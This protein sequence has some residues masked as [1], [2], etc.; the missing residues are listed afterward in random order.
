MTY[1]YDE[2][3]HDEQRTPRRDRRSRRRKKRGFG[4]FIA[5]VLSLAVISVVVWQGY[6]WFDENVRGLFSGPADYEGPGTDPVDITIPEGAFVRDIGNLLRDS[7]V[8]ESSDAFVNA[9][10]ANPDSTSIQA[11][12]YSLRLE[13]R[14][15]DALNALLAGRVSA[16]ASILIPE[17][18][19]LIQ[20]ITRIVDNED[21]EF[22]AEQIQ[23]VLDSPENLTLPE[24][25]EG[26]VEGFLFPATYEVTANM[27]A[28]DLLQAMADR[29]ETAA[30]EAGLVDGAAARGITPRQAVTIAS[31]V[32]REV[33]NIE[34]MPNVAQVIYNRLN[35]SC[36]SNGVPEGYLQMDSTIHFA[37]GESE[38]VFTSDEQRQI[39]SPYNTY[40]NPGIPPGPIA[41]P[42]DDA[43]SAALNPTDGNLCYF[44]AVN[45]ETGETKFAETE[46]EHI[47]NRR[48]LDAYCADSD[49]C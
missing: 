20:I 7:G 23:A 49:A 34:D 2:L 37:L 24:Y 32:Q 15:V 46:D 3:I 29:F 10:N 17:G 31:I 16:V 11:G 19:R 28:Q 45:L 1:G 18:L 14:A 26:S 43:L 39:D 44:V 13:M 33:R 41:A 8:V 36:R 12:T 35:G 9:A 22:T 25:A 30:E 38:G 27:T 6:N 5:V 21:T 40:A 48:E 47:A 42:G 4:S